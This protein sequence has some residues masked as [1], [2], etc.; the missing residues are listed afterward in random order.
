MR[1][2]CSDQALARRG[3]H[4]T[5]PAD[6][7]FIDGYNLLTT[8][9]A[10]LAGGVLM[11]ARDHCLRDMASMHGSWRKVA[12]TGPAL[13]MIGQTI[14][15][16]LPTTWLL[17]APVSNSGRLKT[18]ILQTAAEH[19]WPWQVQVVASP[20]TDLKCSPGVVA[21][22]D[23]VII[24]NCSRWTNLAREVVARHLPAAWIIDMCCA[25]PISNAPSAAP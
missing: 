1:C 19:H 11:I 9:E 7:L 25:N 22:A 4:H 5:A 12:E 18:L 24:D 2:A 17:D 15:P 23:S 13:E 21:T 10:A 16:Y 6:P 14:G 8:V 3:A 20:D